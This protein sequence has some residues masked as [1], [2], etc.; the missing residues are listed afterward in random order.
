MAD[1]DIDHGPEATKYLKEFIGDHYRYSDKPVFKALWDTYNE[2]QFVED[3]GAFLHIFVLTV[4][5]NAET[6]DVIFYRN[7]QGKASVRPAAPYRESS[8]PATDAAQ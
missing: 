2:C 6:G 7:K 1:L 4:V 5:T 8:T 3:E